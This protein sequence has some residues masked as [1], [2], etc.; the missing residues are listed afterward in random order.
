MRDLRKSTSYVAENAL[1]A[2]LTAVY[3]PK[4]K[5][6]IGEYYPD[7]YEYVGQCQCIVC[8]EQRALIDGRVQYYNDDVFYYV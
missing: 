7:L 8:A 5:V 6:D 3:D 1:Y 4:M 2:V